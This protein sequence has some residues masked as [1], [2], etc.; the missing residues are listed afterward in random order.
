MSTRS[1][2]IITSVIERKAAYLYHHCDGYPG[3]VGVDLAE[4]YKDIIESTE[5]KVT[6]NA[7]LDRVTMDSDFE[8]EGSDG[9]IH[10]DIEYLYIMDIEAQAVHCF[11]A[12]NWYGNRFGL[13]FEENGTWSSGM[14][15]RYH[16]N[17]MDE[18]SVQE[19][20]EGRFQ[21]GPVLL[22]FLTFAKDVFIA[23]IEA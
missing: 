14:N 16:A 9:G 18:E 20:K 17:M 7:L 23:T 13:P 12:N 11:K 3:G 5:G 8:N 19:A 22:P 10:G 2:I 4:K 6:F 21:K 15:G 1:S